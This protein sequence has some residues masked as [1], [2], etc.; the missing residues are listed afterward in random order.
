MK[1][2]A[3]LVLFAI[4][5]APGFA[6]SQG[7]TPLTVALGQSAPLSGPSQALGEDVRNGALAYLRTLNEAGGVHGRRIELATLDDAGE[8]KRALANTQ[9]LAEQ[10][11][12]FALLAYPG[13]SVSREVLSYVQQARMPFFAPVTGAQIVRLPGRTVVTVRASHA[14]ELDRAV[15]HYAGLGMKRFA[16]ATGD[17]GADAEFR[18]AF[19]HAL[20]K[21]SLEPAAGRGEADVILVVAA[22][23][24]A[25][26]LVAK[27]KRAR[28][29]AQI[30][31]LSLAEAT[32]LAR[33]LGA[34]GAGVALSLVVPPLERISLPVVGEYRAAMQ[35]ETGRKAYSAASLE[36]FIGA[37]V[38][39]EAVRRAGPSLTRAALMQALESMTAY[40]A[41]GYLLRFG[42]GDRHGSSHTELIA[43]GRNGKLL[44]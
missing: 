7:V 21:R 31:V 37:K 12:V 11:R 3:L 27:L 40:D 33:A 23:R 38:F 6:V 44:H 15:E 35:A 20:N 4:A 26:D 13:P 25:T 39:V 42:H 17:E 34:G 2:R 9:R 22:Q 28:M 5:G 24:P 41:G 30:V 10:L 32:P 29:P 16:L 8:A 36:A 19:A 1:L 18:E 14:E 43:I